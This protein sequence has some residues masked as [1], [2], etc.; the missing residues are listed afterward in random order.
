M[1]LALDARQ[2]VLRSAMRTSQLGLLVLCG[3]EA[4]ELSVLSNLPA[5]VKMLGPG[6]S[7]DELANLSDEDWASIE[8]ILNCGKWHN[9][10]QKEAVRECF[11]KC[12]NVKWMHVVFAGLETVLFP[13]LIESP[14][15]LTN[16]KGVFSHSLAEYV[17]AGCTFFAKDFPRMLAA[18]KA[19]KWDPFSVEDLRGSTLGVIG[20]GN[21]G[22]AT[23]KLAKAYRM[24]V[25]GLRRKTELSESE[26][27]LMDKIYPPSD[28]IAL[29]KECDYVV[30][31]LPYTPKTEKF[32]SREALENMKPNGVFVNVGRGKTVDEEALID[33][34][35]KGKI[36]G[37]VLDVVA[38]EPLPETS[39]LY[40]LDNVFMSAHCADNIK[41][42]QFTSLQLFLEVL[43]MYLTNGELRNVVD[44]SAGY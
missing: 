22:L 28:I 26:K 17:L 36:R 39:P 14:V 19:S 40:K 2:T 43:E 16:G 15:K 11:L 25:V 31:A 32:V 30:A 9:A 3:K 29:T 33:V 35:Q 23:A 13:E 38:M 5:N 18:K 12:K 24:N 37:A 34:L 10:A 6:R 44:K 20:L 41:K 8:V 42:A 7:L 4:P 1:T 21:I 27:Q